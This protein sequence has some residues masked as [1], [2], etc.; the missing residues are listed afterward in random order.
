MAVHRTIDWKVVKFGTYVEDSL[1][2]Y[3]GKYVVSN[4][5]SKAP[6]TDLTFKILPITFERYIL[7]FFL[8]MNECYDKHAK[9]I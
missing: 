9:W 3:H 4:P 1:T 7:E 5:N 2:C 8:Y 6:A